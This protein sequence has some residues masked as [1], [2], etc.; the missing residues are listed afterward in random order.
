[1]RELFSVEETN[2]MCIY[3]T[4]SRTALLNDLVTGL[5]DIYDPDMIAIF[6]SAIE[7]LEAVTDEEFADIGFYIADDFIDEEV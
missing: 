5:H 6:G 2:L 1:M 7:K 4:S 3:D